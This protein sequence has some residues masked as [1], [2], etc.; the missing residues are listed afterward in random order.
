MKTFDTHAAQG[1]LS[2][3]R[4][5]RSEIPA[6][7]K[8]VSP[9]GDVFVMGHSETGHHH[10]LDRAGA[11][12]LEH[13]SPPAGMRILYA[14]LDEHNALTHQRPFD[15]HEPFAFTPDVYEFRQNREFDHYEKLARKQAD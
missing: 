4:I 1:E 13:P 5:S 14:F 8:P 15:T 12:V 3:R 6:G 11:T 7:A 2:I 9:D 10:V